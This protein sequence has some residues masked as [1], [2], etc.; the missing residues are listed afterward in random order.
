MLLASTLGKI[1]C[2][3]V[4]PKVLSLFVFYI[5]VLSHPVILVA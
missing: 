5:K 1:L 4:K 3:S 2:K